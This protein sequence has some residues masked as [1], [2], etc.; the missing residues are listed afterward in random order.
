MISGHIFKNARISGSMAVERVALL[1]D[2]FFEIDMGML[3]YLKSSYYGKKYLAALKPM[4]VQT[5]DS[6]VLVDT[7]ICDLPDS[8]AKI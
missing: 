2:G 1:H 5:G 3:V 8:Y 4:L 7:G 6:N